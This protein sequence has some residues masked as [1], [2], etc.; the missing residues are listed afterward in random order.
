VPRHC[1]IL[2]SSPSCSGRRRAPRSP[3][4]FNSCGHTPDISARHISSLV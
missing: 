1:T 4:L 2:L 3:D